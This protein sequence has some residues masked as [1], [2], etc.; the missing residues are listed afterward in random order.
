VNPI[1]RIS[2]IVW[3]ARETSSPLLGLYNCLMYVV[4]IYVFAYLIEMTRK[5]P[6]NLVFS[7]LSEPYQI[8][9][10]SLWDPFLY[11]DFDILADRAR[12]VEQPRVFEF[13]IPMLIELAIR[14]L[15]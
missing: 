13:L 3:Y 12:Y 1:E 10:Y 9:P 2:R 11:S 7:T 15:I 14:L 4:K 6:L 5:R 8:E